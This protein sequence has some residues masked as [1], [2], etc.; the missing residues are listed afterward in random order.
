MMRSARRLVGVLAALPLAA[1]I[2]AAAS[3]ASGAAAAGGRTP[4]Q[5]MPY[6]TAPAEGAIWF[7]ERRLFGDR[8]E[9]WIGRITS[10]GRVTSF[11]A[12][13]PAGPPRPGERSDPSVFDITADPA[14][15]V[16]FA[17]TGSRIGRLT[18]TGAVRRF[19]TGIPEPVQIAS[20]TWGPDGNLW[21]TTNARM[22]GRMTPAG[23][24]TRFPL[25]V[26][27]SASGITTGPGGTL[28]FVLS[29]QQNDGWVEHL[30]TITAD[31]A[32][33]AS[34][35]LTG[36]SYVGVIGNLTSGPDGNLWFSRSNRIGLITPE[37]RVTMRGTR[38]GP[39][40]AITSLTAGPDGNLWFT[41][42]SAHYFEPLDRPVGRMTPA[43]IV[44]FVPTRTEVTDL[45]TGSDGNLWF[46]QPNDER[47][48][49][50]SPAGVVS[51]FP[52]VA[53]VSALTGRGARGAVARLRCPSSAPFTCRGTITLE[54]GPRGRRRGVAAFSVAPGT[55]AVVP[56]PLWPAGRRLLA[57]RRSLS[58]HAV[59]R[60]RSAHTGVLGGRITRP[61]VL[62]LPAPPAA[63][64]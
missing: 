50:L 3:P 17:G 46:V 40:D 22:I 7:T 23:A 8:E 37:G 6:S 48:G 33:T 55:A 53:R 32:I 43:G 16:W 21:F 51:E 25:P 34:G 39:D 26:G 54:S 63:T 52:P 42:S 9:S 41:V 57:A 29:I 38:V 4:L 19:P 10:R 35:P 60:P 18:P 58:L 15:N 14:G 47:L 5:S 61:V 28:W 30:A 24:V 36:P 13:L 45:T 49:R 44:T 64:R 62:R 11:R 31:G 56:V 2:A 12:R 59:L 27:R 20:L 1:G